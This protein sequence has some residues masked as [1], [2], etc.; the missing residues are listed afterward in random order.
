[1]WGESAAVA[2]NAIACSPDGAR[3]AVRSPAQR[4]VNVLGGCAGKGL[5]SGWIQ[6]SNRRREE[7]AE[8]PRA[9][10]PQV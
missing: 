9:H 10:Q 6:P 5:R 8:V 7:A 2:A 1:M 4:N 3:K